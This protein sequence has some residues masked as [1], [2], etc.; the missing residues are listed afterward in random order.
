MDRRRVLGAAASLAG[1]WAAYLA[2]I[3]FFRSFLPSQKALA[4]GGP[5]EVDLAEIKPGQ[6]KAY[7][8]RGRTMLVLRRTPA[9]LEAVDSMRDRLRDAGGEDP[10]Y[11]ANANRSIRPEFLVIEGVC[12]HLACVPKLRDPNEGRAMVG[13]WWA[14]GF[15]CPCHTSGFDYAG[16]S[17]RGPASR[18]LPVP[19][20]RYVSPTRIVIGEEPL[21]T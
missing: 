6:V 14:G 5:V 1:V 2:S 8:Y 10:A 18:N 15:L 16:R 9:M 3:P 17:V 12:T 20:H 13:E 21:P 19:P 11:V 7:A 4:L